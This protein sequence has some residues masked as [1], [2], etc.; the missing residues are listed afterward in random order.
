MTAQ[1]YHNA[2]KQTKLKLLFAR[3]AAAPQ[4]GRRDELHGK[5]YVRTL[6]SVREEGIAWSLQPDCNTIVT[7]LITM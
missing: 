6:T 5:C 2:S 4:S 7:Q 3:C 1:N